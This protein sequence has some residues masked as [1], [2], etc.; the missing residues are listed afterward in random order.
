MSR[1]AAI[2]GIESYFDSGAFQEELT[3]RI[4]IPT[5]SQKEDSQAH[6]QRYLDEAM[7]PA[8]EKMGFSNKVFANPPTKTSKFAGPLALWLVR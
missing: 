5:E 1:K 4:A 7:K 3:A 6:L 2:D 8:F